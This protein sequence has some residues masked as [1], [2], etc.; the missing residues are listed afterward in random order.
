M[1]MLIILSIGLVYV[2]YG[3]P[4]P[5][6][7]MGSL[8]DEQ[9]ERDLIREPDLQSTYE[10][11]YGEIGNIASEMKRNAEILEARKLAEDLMPQLES[12]LESRLESQLAP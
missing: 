9:I 4:A 10:T 11:V 1:S 8:L 3:V 7:D 12:Q 5:F 6:H 2:F